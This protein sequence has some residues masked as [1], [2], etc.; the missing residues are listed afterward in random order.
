MMRPG[1]VFLLLITVF[2][3]CGKEDAHGSAKG[4]L[5][6]RWKLIAIKDKSTNQL[7]VPPPGS[8]NRVYLAFKGNRFSGQTMNNTITDGTFTLNTSNSIT[9]ENYTSSLATEN[10][11]G[12]A[13]LTVLAASMLQSIHPCAPSVITWLSPDKIEINTALRYTITLEKM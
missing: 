2:C 3:G 9:F 11:W 4:A 10:E 5:D 13:L 12:S 6:G 8:D 7:L 1:L